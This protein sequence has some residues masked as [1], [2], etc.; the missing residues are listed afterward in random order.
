MSADDHKIL[1]LSWGYQI[2][3][4]LRIGIDPN[5]LEFIN[6]YRCSTERNERVSDEA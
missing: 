6:S 3:I 2:G 1:N 5:L 4:T